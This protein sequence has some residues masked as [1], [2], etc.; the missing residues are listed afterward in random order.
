MRLMF[1]E[2]S[3]E[4]SGNNVVRLEIARTIKAYRDALRRN[5]GQRGIMERN[6]VA[7]A[8]ARKNLE[9]RGI[10]WNN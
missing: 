7:V 5:F 2:E 8:S 4:T 9:R 3:D 1:I 6:K 10:L